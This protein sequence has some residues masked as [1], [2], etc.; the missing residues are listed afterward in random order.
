MLMIAVEAASIVVF[1]L[2]DPLVVFFSKAKVFHSDS[3]FCYF[4][5]KYVRSEWV[6]VSDFIID[7]FQIRVIS[8]IG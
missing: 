8:S 5:G 6:T 2:I 3:F 7:C 1:V 4:T